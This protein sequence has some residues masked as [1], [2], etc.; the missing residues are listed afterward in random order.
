MKKSPQKKNRI[1]EADRT[2]VKGRKNRLSSV[3]NENA[4]M[5]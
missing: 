5:Y 4:K 3:D 2:I 1:V